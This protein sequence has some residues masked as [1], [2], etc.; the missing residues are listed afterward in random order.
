[1]QQFVR[2]VVV[3][4]GIAGCGSVKN[5]D[6]P[7]APPLSDAPVDAPPAPVKATVL[8]TA[9]DGAPDTTAKLVFQ[10]AD[11]A[12]VFDGPVDGMG[13][14]QALLPG[15]G[16][17][18]AIRILIDTTDELAAAVTTITGVKPGDDLTFG[19]KPPGTILNQ[20]GATTMTAT[21]TP[22]PN[23]LSY[24]FY[25]P[26]GSVFAAAGS[27]SVAL[28]FRDSCHGAT[29]DLVGVAAFTAPAAPQFIKLTNVAYK[30]GETFAIPGGFSTM[31]EFAVNMTNIPDA[32]SNLAVLR[33]SMIGNTTA[34]DQS[35]SPGDPPAGSFSVAVP[36]P[37]G[38]GTRSQISVSL[39]R[40][41]K[42][43]PQRLEL[44]T[45]TLASNVSV[46]LG[47]QLPW[48]AD[49]TTTATG[50]TWTPVAPGD[51]PDGMLTQWSGRWND[52]KRQVSIQW[53][54]VHPAEASGMTL[55]RLPAAYAMIDPGQQT[56]AV[57]SGTPV[58]SMADY[59]NVAGYDGLR[60]MPETLLIPAMSTIGVF[61]D[62]PFQRRIAVFG[63]FV[64][65]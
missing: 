61:T 51:P 21:F 1:M 18:S 11:G 60:Q 32:I 19:L 56:V 34:A 44:R 8:T 5:G 24:I 35:V 13:R 3:L 4:I 28:P 15:G 64:G 47:N 40:S 23:A 22:A 63:R 39:S 65:R 9:A 45:A 55:P 41:D 59:N 52:G 12:V 30:S 27:A 17:V 14:A 29:F 58:L 43:V 6:L 48:I 46:D 53:R 16:T 37:Q 49:P 57:T 38:F 54:V 25:T 2:F 42:T 26:C 7:D 20:G 33:S 10:D 36:F 31:A 62:V 50:M